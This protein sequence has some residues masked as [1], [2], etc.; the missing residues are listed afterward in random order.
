MGAIK[1]PGCDLELPEDDL[2]AQVEHME[3]NHPEIIIQRLKKEGLWD[4]E[5]NVPLHPKFNDPLVRPW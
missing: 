4:E 5:K 1:C 2:G 3:Q